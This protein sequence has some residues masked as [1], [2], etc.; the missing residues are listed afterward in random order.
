MHRFRPARRGFSLLEI[1]MTTVLASLLLALGL[2]NLRP[3]QDSA[4]STG[5][6]MVAVEQLRLAR[7]KAMAEH[8]WVAILVPSQNGNLP[9]SQSLAIV[10]GKS[11]GRVTKTLGFAGD[12]PGAYLFSGFWDSDGSAFQVTPTVQ[13]M[14]PSDL[15]LNSWLSSYSNEPCLV[16][17]PQGSATSNKLPYKDGAYR[18]VACAGVRWQNST[19]PSGI[20]GGPPAEVAVATA[21]AKPCT[22]SVTPSGQVSYQSGLPSGA[23]CPLEPRGW[24]LALVA[25]TPPRDGVAVASP[26]VEKLEVSPPPALVREPDVDVTIGP[27]QRLTLTAIVKD[28]SGA[29][30]LGRWDVRGATSSGD[31]GAFSSP[32]AQPLDWDPKRQRWIS[33]IDWVAPLSALPN[34][35]FSFDFRLGGSLTALAQSNPPAFETDLAMMP[36]T[37]LFTRLTGVLDGVNGDYVVRSNTDGSYPEVL[38]AKLTPSWT[39]PN[40]KIALNHDGSRF[41]LFGSFNNSFYSSVTGEL[42]DTFFQSTGYAAEIG[43]ASS[44][45]AFFRI[46]SNP[47]TSSTMFGREIQGTLSVFSQS[48]TDQKN[49]L[50][51]NMPGSFSYQGDYGLYPKGLAWSPDEQWLGFLNPSSRYYNSRQLNLVKADG[52]GQ[53]LLR[54]EVRR[55]NGLEWS[56]DGKTLFVADGQELLAYDLASGAFLNGGQPFTDLSSNAEFMSSRSFSSMQLGSGL[57][58]FTTSLDNQGFYVARGNSIWTMNLDG[59]GLKKVAELPAGIRYV[60]TSPR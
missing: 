51:D 3:A 5:L 52:T 32:G 20:S 12:L 35:R 38:H 21:L 4:G 39:L 13:G 41:M 6:A 2:M 53:R 10:E 37:K 14:R 36:K 58:A 31:S 57:V 44:K 24:S 15:D 50:F 16:F 9:A 27:G 19:L 28:F 22:I 49:L 40:A 48:G 25:P 17:N 45:V 7:Q 42:L 46:Y 47:G 33:K 59:T 23:R 11:R 54:P 55:Y 30:L 56:R 60:A 1:L 18:L 29:D 8:Q 43:A 34:D 26:T